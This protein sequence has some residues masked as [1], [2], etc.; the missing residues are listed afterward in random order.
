VSLVPEEEGSAGG[1]DY[2]I[3][4]VPFTAVR[5]T[6]AFWGPRI[7]TN[8]QVT[9]PYCL[10][11]CE[12]T[13]RIANFAR[14]GGL[15]EGGFEGIFFNDSDVYKVLEGAAYALAVEPDAEL[16]ARIDEVIRKIVSAQWE[17]GYLYTFYSLP[18]RQP[19]KRWSDVRNMHELYCAGHLFEA[20]VA[21]H[22]ATGKRALL[23]AALRLA[24]H[25]CT[26]FGPE[27]NTCPPGHEEIEIGLVK[28]Y[29]VTGER[30]YL[31]LAEFFVRAR[32]ETWGGRELSGSY[33]QDHAPIGEQSEAVG[34]AVRA[35]YFYAGAADVAALTGSGSLTQAID[36]LWSN[37]VSCKLYVTGAIGARHAGESFGDDFELPNATAYAETCASIAN[38]F[39]NHRMFLLRGRSEYV[40][41]LERSLYNAMLSGVSLSGDRFFYPNPLASDGVTPFNHGSLER[42]PWFGCSCCPVNV[43]RAVA[44]IGQYIYALREDAL[45]V[46]L[47]I[48]NHASLVVDGVPVRVEVD[49]DMPYGGSSLLTLAPAR[50]TRFTLC[51]RIPDWAEGHTTPGGLYRYA[52][53]VEA[54]PVLRV[55][56]ETVDWEEEDGFARVTRRWSEGDTVEWILATPIR[57]VV[58][59]SRVE[60]NRGRVALQRGPL[61]YCLEGVDNEGHALDAVLPSG[62][63]IDDRYRPE[64]LGGTLVLELEGQVVQRD[65][66]TA[67]IV[68]VPQPFVAV[69]YS[70]W[71]NRDPAP[72]C[73]WIAVDPTVAEPAPL[74]TIASLSKVTA[75]HVWQ[76]DTARACNDQRLPGASDDDSIPRM[77]WWDHRGTREWVQ[78]EFAEPVRVKGVEV[79]WFDDTGRG[80]C[81]VPAAWRVFYREGE[82]WREVT[83]ADPCG[84]VPN[85]FNAVAFDPVET[86]ALRLDV[87]L[88]QDVSAGVLEWVVVPAE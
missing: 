84:V 33:F 18:E 71:A 39:W 37:V 28:L 35:G 42:Q 79:Y 77:T 22:A 58:A 62:G 65:P 46:N 52:T 76:T 83:G 67:G 29:R 87:Q 73:V 69:P 36:R 13:G 41:V 61:V 55:N 43:A 32:G 48:S 50:R 23:D 9:I 63:E 34:H 81:R 30:R 25:I 44:A 57:R 64:V 59:D 21:Y 56:G 24:D 47:F 51:L 75:S 3:T 66:G 54:E 31:D 20:A 15:E 86:D 82:E 80:S 17:D 40:D 12:E 68:S 14:A 26:V 5:V 49:S 45:F 88:Q 6:D 85:A 74:P 27:G 72:M 70:L 1:S 2:P 7:E 19:G 11:K 10:D 4:P 38:V 78:Y 16:E 60:A 53:P 8:R